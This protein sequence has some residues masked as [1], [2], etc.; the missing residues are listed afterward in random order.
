MMA[1]MAIYYSDWSSHDFDDVPA[2]ARLCELT[3]VDLARLVRKRMVSP[4]DVVRAHLDRIAALDPV[5]G[6]FQV[7]RAE[8]ALAEARALTLRSDLSRLPLAGVPVA[9]KDNVAVAGE[10]TRMG[11]AATSGEP[12]GSDDELVARLRAAGCVVI[13]KTTLPELAIWP[14]TESAAFGPTRNPWDPART[15]GGSTG[16]GAAAVAAGM[17]ALAIGS[18][19]G[20]SIRI[21]AAC[22]GLLGV[23]PGPGLV[24]LAGGAAE[25]WLGLTAFGPIARTV[26]DA[27]LALDVLAGRPIRRDPPAQPRPLRIAFSARH[28]LPGVS[29]SRPVLAALDD[30]AGVLRNAGH[31]LTEDAPRYPVTLGLRFDARWLAGIARDADGLDAAALEPRTRRLARTGRRI[32]GRVRPA[33]ADA[34]ATRAARWF[35]SYDVLITPTLTRAP[36]PVGAWDGAGWIATMLGS[37]RW[38]CTPQWN[39]AGLPALSVP[40]GQDDDGLPIGMQ[41]IGPAGSERLLLELAAQI[42]SLRPWPRLAPLPGS[43]SPADPPADPPAEAG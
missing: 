38:I 7:V 28:P 27:A 22:C 17:A 3:A 8:A 24:P 5:L 35:A 20:G 30:L 26:A 14:F 43:G 19:G 4:V 6:A 9:I 23:K 15:P 29:A 34:F 42:E 21:P 2:G 33:S 13:G 37:A 16:G 31:A 10:P 25:H 1:Y 12:A 41:L 18:D 36:V 11:S 39:L 40:F 32:A